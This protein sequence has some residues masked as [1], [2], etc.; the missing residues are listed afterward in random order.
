MTAFWLAA[1]TR[2]F[3]AAPTRRVYHRLCLAR[4]RVREYTLAAPPEVL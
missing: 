1:W 4:A 3:D 2:A